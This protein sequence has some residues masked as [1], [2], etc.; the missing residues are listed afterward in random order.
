ML[1]V[2]VQPQL[3][4]TVTEYDPGQSEELVADVI[5]LLQRYV[6]ILEPPIAETVAEPL[7]AELQVMLIPLTVEFI[8]ES[9]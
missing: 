3:S 7:Q 1:P 5:A 2:A 9:E 4:V 8:C 6:Y